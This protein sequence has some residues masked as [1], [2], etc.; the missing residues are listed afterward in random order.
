MF[1]TYCRLNVSKVTVTKTAAKP[2][3]AAAAMTNRAMSAYSG[4]IY[5][6]AIS[7]Q[8]ATL[9]F[10]SNLW[11]TERQMSAFG[12]T[13]LADQKEKGFK[14]T[15]ANGTPYML[16]N[17]MQTSDPAKIEASKGKLAA[18]NALTKEKFFG[19][20][21]AAFNAEMS[22]YKVNE[23][24]GEKEVQGLNLALQANA[25]PVSIQMEFEDTVSTPEG[26]KV[27]KKVVTKSY[28]NVAQLQNPEVVEKIR[29][30]YP[31]STSTGKRYTPYMAIPLLKVALERNYES[32]FWTTM[33]G[34]QALG[35]IVK[36]P[37][38]GVDI[39]VT[40]NKVLTFYN[41]SQTSNPSKVATAAY[42]AQFAPRS[43]FSG[44]PYPEPTNSALS[45]AALKKKLRSVYW[46][47][48]KQAAFLGVSVLD[49]QEPTE[50]VMNDGI[51]R[52]YN[53]DQ[54]NGKEAIEARNRGK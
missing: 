27:E 9:G 5:P 52:L 34:A 31:I 10:K 46:L 24:I 1:R 53:A 41:A 30:A 32:P 18:Y 42:R 43:A 15:T 21:E 50:V 29:K 7:E 51:I 45:T 19:N 48:E 33:Q 23:W 26:N 54:T 39:A 13:L 36:D 49:G 14:T 16:Y 17:A 37:M 4:N 20:L 40:D 25:T 8:L 38:A 35:L 11:L 28:Y 2:I 12:V 6:V 3:A 47:T 44:S 22:K